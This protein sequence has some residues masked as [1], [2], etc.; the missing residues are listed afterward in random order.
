MKSFAHEREGAADA[1][2]EELQQLRKESLDREAKLKEALQSEARRAE[3]Q[4]AREKALAVVKTQETAAANHQRE[5]M[6]VKD[7]LMEEKQSALAEQRQQHAAQL[8]EL[9]RKVQ[10]REEEK[11]LL[12]LQ[13]EESRQSVAV[14]REEAS[15]QL[16]QQL[17]EMRGVGV[18]TT[19]ACRHICSHLCHRVFVT[20]SVTLIRCIIALLHASTGTGVGAPTEPVAGGGE[21]GSR[22][23][24]P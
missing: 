12:L 23:S 11:R 16:K 7:H 20:S 4:L 2:A 15:R 14:A 19:A 6:E 24:N 10:V 8:E 17:H 18:H 5:L 13:L 9:T 1:L 22:G 3:K 21:A